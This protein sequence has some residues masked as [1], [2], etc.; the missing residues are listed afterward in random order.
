MLFHVTDEVLLISQSANVFVF[1][2]YEEVHPV[3]QGSKAPRSLPPFQSLNIIVY[4]RFEP[5]FWRQPSPLNS[6]FYIFSTSLAFGKTFWQYHPNEIPDK[7]QGMYPRP[8]PAW[9]GGG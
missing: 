2:W 7:H 1:A 5:L 9:E 4:R 8:P 6:I 3:I